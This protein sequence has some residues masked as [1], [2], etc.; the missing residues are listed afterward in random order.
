[1]GTQV[2]GAAA[3]LVLGCVKPA[4]NE[5]RKNELRIKSKEVPQCVTWSEPHRDTG[6]KRIQTKKCPFRLSTQY[7]ALMPAQKLCWGA[8]VGLPETDLPCQNGGL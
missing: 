5:D 7:Q 6:A 4:N 8:R 3:N 1:M 2:A